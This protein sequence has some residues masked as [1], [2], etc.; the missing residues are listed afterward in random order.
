MEMP[1]GLKKVCFI[2]ETP[3]SGS[4]GSSSSN[5]SRNTNTNDGDATPYYDTI[6]TVPDDKVGAF[7]CGQLD[8]Y[9]RLG[10]LP[11]STNCDTLRWMIHDTN[12]CGCTTVATA[13]TSATTTTST[14]TSTASSSRMRTT[15][16][17]V[18]VTV[19]VGV[20]SLLLSFFF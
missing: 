10:S 18:T 5:S 8:D 6:V 19:T 17:I 1:K 4:N 14:P 9:G 20:P 7:T 11:S 15:T 3:G 13:T 12:L 16:A 2:C